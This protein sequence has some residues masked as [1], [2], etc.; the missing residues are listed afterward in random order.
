MPAFQ[1]HTKIQF[2]M[3][4]EEN[5][6]LPFLNVLVLRQSDGSMGHCRPI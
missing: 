1:S 2:T 6:C 3:E 5:G 4:T